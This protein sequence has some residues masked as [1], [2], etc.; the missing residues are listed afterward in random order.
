MNPHVQIGSFGTSLRFALL[1]I[2]ILRTVVTIAQ[3]SAERSEFGKLDPAEF[4]LTQCDFDPNA[5]ALVLFDLGEVDIWQYLNAMNSPQVDIEFKRHVRIKI[6]ND[7]GLSAADVKIPYIYYRGIEKIQNI[8][9]QTYNLESNG[10]ISISKMDR[11]AIYDHEVNKAVSEKAFTLPEVRAGSILEY[12]FTISGGIYAGIRNWEFQRTFPVRISQYSL[13]T[14][15]PLIVHSEAR[16]RFPFEETNQGKGNDLK[17]VFTMRDIPA[18]REEPFIS[19]HADLAQLVQ[20]SVVGF[21][22]GNS[23]YSGGFSWNSM[24][25]LLQFS[26]EFGRQFSKVIAGVEDLNQVLDSM[27]DNYGKMVTIYYYVRHKMHWDGLNGLLS[28]TRIDSAWF[29]RKGSSVDINLILFNL[30]KHANLPAALL[31]VKSRDHGKIDMDRPNFSEFDHVMV[32][33]SL[34]DRN[35]ILDASDAY[36]SPKLIP[37]PAMQTKGI[38]VGTVGWQWIDIWD[39]NQFLKNIVQISASVS[40]EGE[41]SGEATVNSYDFSRQTRSKE[42]QENRA[43]F[44]KHYFDASDPS[45]RVDS[46]TCINA[47]NDTLPLIQK[48]EFSKKLNSSGNYSYFSTNLFTGLEKNPFVADA[49]FADVFFRANQY[50][51]LYGSFLIPDGFSF[52]ALPK[53]IL[54]HMADGSITFSRLIQVEGDNL[55]IQCILEFKKPM[56]QAS[57][58]PEF[59][60]FYKKLEGCL[61]EQIVLKK[62]S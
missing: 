11:K 55:S 35:F 3:V 28:R 26:P 51:A 22:Y 25:S 19:S 48:V 27:S 24:V 15:F 32:L 61:N 45:M 4:A 17:H 57:E 9:A 41:L 40:P 5:G 14:Q 58:Y 29:E 8:K 33:V 54:L 44:Q 47:E 31:L 7:N 1:P 20:S 10:K 12:E 52:D 56:Y 18:L 53:N 43:D 21:R 13:R 23:E 30:F 60:E 38:L 39:G 16:A 36:G 49:R 34:D 62:K 37:W 2:L 59:H 6:F 50:Y 46:M 42:F